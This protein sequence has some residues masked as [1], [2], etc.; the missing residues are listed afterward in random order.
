[1]TTKPATKLSESLTRKQLMHLELII[2]SV[3]PT[4]AILIVAVAGT[5]VQFNVIFFTL[6][7]LICA[8]AVFFTEHSI[9]LRMQQ[10]M[11]EQLTDLITACRTFIKGNKQ[12]RVSMPG[13]DQLAVL[14]STLNSLFDHMQTTPSP[15]KEKENAQAFEAKTRLL[16]ITNE[17]IDLINQQLEQLVEDISPALDGDLRVQSSI[18]EDTSDEGVAMVADLCNAL[19]EKLV[20]F[21]RWT[22]YASDRV[23]STSRNVLDRSMELAQTTEVQM[24]ALGTMTAAVEKLV[25]FIQRMGSALQ[26]NADMAQEA[27][28]HLQENQASVNSSGTRSVLQQLTNNTQRQLQLLEEILESTHN[29]TTIA[30]SAIGD[31]YAFAQQFHQSSTAVIKTAESINVIVTIAED[32]RNAADALYLPDEDEQEDLTLEDSDIETQ[33]HLGRILSEK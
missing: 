30:E 15:S 27:Y 21:T 10:A 1:M 24:L 17:T 9:I 20:Q 29:T 2:A 8:I 16:D 12:T 6:D 18:A 31:L 23:I 33:D 22:L 3:V 28:F 11:D 7:V 25:A 5:A 14:A 26:L 13:D 4:A 19:V 32:W